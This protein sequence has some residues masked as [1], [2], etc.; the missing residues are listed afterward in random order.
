MGSPKEILGQ[1]ADM[2]IESEF[3]YKAAYLKLRKDYPEFS[4][5]DL[6]M[7]AK[8]ERMRDSGRITAKEYIALTETYDSRVELENEYWGIYGTDPEKEKELEVRKARLDKFLGRYGVKPVSF[9]K[10]LDSTIDNRKIKRAREQKDPV[11]SLG[12]WP[13]E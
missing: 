5:L 9:D 3:S 1:V 2:N 6:L 4:L 8:I 13:L 10:F 7:Y 12:T 11:K